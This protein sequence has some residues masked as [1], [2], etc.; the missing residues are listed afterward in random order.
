MNR[1]ALPI[2]ALVPLLAACPSD[3]KNPST[4]WLA[5]DGGETE[6]KLVEQ[7]PNPF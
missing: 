1:L 6:V 3:D 4:L 2:V 7:E 5:L